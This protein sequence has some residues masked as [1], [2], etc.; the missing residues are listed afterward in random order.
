MAR[1]NRLKNILVDSDLVVVEPPYRSV[2]PDPEKPGRISHPRDIGAKWTDAQLAKIGLWPVYEDPRP[3]KND[4]GHTTEYVRRANGKVFRQ[5]VPI[6]TSAQDI[7]NEER[8]RVMEGFN[9]LQGES[10]ERAMFMFL[11]ALLEFG[12]DK[13]LWP[14]GTRTLYT[15]LEPAL[16]DASRLRAKADTLKGTLPAD[17]RHER[18]W[19]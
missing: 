3:P 15:L 6:A 9:A 14:V 16:T 8:R 4:A 17:Y 12:A 1:L 7:D 13:T 11:E 18:H 5:Y 2:S 19:R 10:Y